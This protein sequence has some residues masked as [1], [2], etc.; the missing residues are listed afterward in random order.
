M[1][2]CP[3][4]I[5]AFFATIKLGGIIL[6]LFSGYG[7]D[8]VST[9]LRDAEA[10]VLFTV[11]GCWRRG[12]PVHM[13]AVADEAALSSPS[14]RHVVV[15]SRLGQDVPLTP[16]R[17]HRWVDC[18]RVATGVVRHRADERR[19]PVDDH[20]HVR[21][22]GPAEGSCAHALRLPDQGRAGHGPRLR[23]A[24]RRDDVLDQRHGLDDGPVGSLRDDAARRHLRPLR[25]RPRLPWTRIGSGRSSNATA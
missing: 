3:E 1:P 15:V 8:A 9:R 7:A 23:R 17:D 16:G 10:S 14:L 13:K 22:D 5:V 18:P 6:P 25:R 2:M 12:Q 21:H 20:L 24:R 4:L 19:R 11:D